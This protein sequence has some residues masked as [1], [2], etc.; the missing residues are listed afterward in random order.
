MKSKSKILKFFSNTL[1]IMVMTLAMSVI[2]SCSK[3]SQQNIDET[4][5]TTKSDTLERRFFDKGVIDDTLSLNLLE[6]KNLSTKLTDDSYR[7]LRYDN[8]CPDQFS[9]V[10]PGAC[11]YRL[12]NVHPT[13]TI[14][15]FV[16]KSYPYNNQ[17]FHEDVPFTLVKGNWQHFG[18]HYVSTTQPIRFTIYARYVEQVANPIVL[19]NKSTVDET[20]TCGIYSEGSFICYENIL[21]RCISDPGSNACY[22]Y[23]WGTACTTAFF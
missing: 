16:R 8:Y 22:W 6:T 5:V 4:K 2:I 15:G 17:T 12:T 20:C 14:A 3:Q 9:C 10:V 11:Y 1:P 18:C 23:N 13:K 21:Y 7:Y 19:K